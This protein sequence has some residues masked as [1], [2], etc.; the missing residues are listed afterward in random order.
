MRCKHLVELDSIVTCLASHIRRSADDDESSY[1][2][3]DESGAKNAEEGVTTRQKRSFADFLSDEI[4]SVDTMRLVGGLLW[5]VRQ[6]RKQL[7]GRCYP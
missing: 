4:K 1:Y 5:E 7:G 6:Y 3:D 2:E